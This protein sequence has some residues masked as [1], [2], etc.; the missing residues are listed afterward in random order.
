[1]NETH[2]SVFHSAPNHAR[3]IALEKQYLFRGSQCF[4]LV[5]LVSSKRLY[6]IH[7]TWFDNFFT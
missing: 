4:Q 1:M 2:L 3:E 7:D 6:D 5:F